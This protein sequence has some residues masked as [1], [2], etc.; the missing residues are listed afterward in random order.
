[1]RARS[2]AAS[3]VRHVGGAAVE[4]TLIAT[5]VATVAIAL[6]PVYAPAGSLAGLG[7]ANAAP[8]SGATITAVFPYASSSDSYPYATPYVV[9]GCGYDPANGGVTV[10]VQSPEAYSFAGGLPD[11]AGCVSVTNFSTQG[12]GTYYL[13][14]YQTV[15]HKSQVMAKSSFTLN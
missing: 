5:L 11:S 1:M 15:R 9:T 2:A 13:T 3:V 14:A 12:P 7:T 8:K 6:G 4:A 10:V